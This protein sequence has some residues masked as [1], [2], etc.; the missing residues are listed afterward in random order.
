M[1]SAR[2]LPGRH[3]SL[4]G[5][6]GYPAAGLP[7]IKKFYV[8]LMLPVVYSAVRELRQARWLTLAWSAAAAIGAADA[9]VQFL[10]KSRKPTRPGKHSTNTMFRDA[11]PAS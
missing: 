9:L 6:S 5:F 2:G 3:R 4:A 7:Q 1:G 11:L 10:R 8:Y